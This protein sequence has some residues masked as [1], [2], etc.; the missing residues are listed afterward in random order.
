MYAEDPAFWRAGAIATTLVMA[1]VLVFLT[2]DSLAAIRTGGSHVPPYTVINQA[3][4]L[5]IYDNKLTAICRSSARPS[6]CTG[7]RSMRRRQLA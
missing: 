5:R 4:T 7:S 6:R 2:I 3:V 1:V